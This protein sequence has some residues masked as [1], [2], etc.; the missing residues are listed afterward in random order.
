[1]KQLSENAVEGRGHEG[2]YPRLSR[3]ATAA[4]GL[5]F[6][7]TACGSAQDMQHEEIGVAAQEVT[8]TCVDI[9]RAAGDTVEDAMIELSASDPTVA[10]QNF[11]KRKS[12][13]TRDGVE[14]TR[15]ALLRFELT[16][17]VPPGN[18][19]TR[20]YLELYQ[21]QNQTGLLFAH[22]LTSPWSEGTATFN[23][24]AG[25][26]DGI[27]SST[28]PQLKGLIR[29]DMHDPVSSWVYGSTPNYGVLLSSS[30]LVNRSFASSEAAAPGTA[31]VLVVC[32]A[33]SSPPARVLNA[34]AYDVARDNLLLF[35]GVGAGGDLGDLW[36]RNGFVWRQAM[37]AVIPSARRNVRAVYDSA[38]DR[39]VLFG[40][41]SGSTPLGDTWE[42]D[43]KYWS[44]S[45][46]AASPSARLTHALAYDAHRHVVVLFG[47]TT[48]ISGAVNLND[49]WEWDG[50][51]WTQRAT[52]VQPSPRVSVMAFDSA[53]NVTV[54]FGGWDGAPNGETWEWDGTTWLLRVPTDPEGDGNPPPTQGPALS[55]DSARG[56]T[57]L[58]GGSAVL[59]GGGGKVE[60]NQTWEWNGTS[61][62]HAIP[63]DPEGDGDPAP[64]WTELAYHS[65]RGR[66]VMF[67]GM[68]NGVP[69]GDT[70]EWNGVSWASWP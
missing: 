29:M 33:P 53:R 23:S 68:S 16:G 65:G 43:G 34:L 9:S 31:P 69:Q 54:L 2:Q 63:T 51:A 37:K 62:R 59:A 8:E 18:F 12:L 21:L 39:I 41:V 19:V 26:F 46:P 38:R 25:T 35:G 44:P 17:K 4:I 64:R 3:R 6:V 52:A 10:D 22:L 45:S 5:A 70:W 66:V 60:T 7:C 30:Q 47:G 49:T 55:Y 13:E 32:Y 56:V 58:F 28:G 48:S 24:V 50:T 15:Y 67:G 14:G 57:V 61:W 40:G 36:E 1:V 42:W 20:A 27:V 11:G